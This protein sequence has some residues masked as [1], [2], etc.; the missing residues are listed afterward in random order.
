MQG[1]QRKDNGS[2]AL[3]S[4]VTFEK[5]LVVER[6]FREESK[7]TL[8]RKSPILRKCEDLMEALW[9]DGYHHEIS[10]RLLKEYV[11]AICGGFR[12]TVVDYLGR[13][14]KYYRS[15]GRMGV[16]KT[17]AKQ[18]YLEKFG[19]IEKRSLKI[20]ILHH[21]R[22]N[23]PYHN[24]QTNIVSFSLSNSRKNGKGKEGE[25][26]PTNYTTLL[27]HTQREREIKKFNQTC[28]KLQLTHDEMRALRACQRYGG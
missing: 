28:Q 25:I 15:R 4:S 10:W 7:P 20:V 18:G 21:E 9:E 1:R 11:I 26:A 5:R 2:E 8:R 24:E 12:T 3:T 19:F 13:R 6:R 27:L 23:R 22:V 14:A 16:L 17:P